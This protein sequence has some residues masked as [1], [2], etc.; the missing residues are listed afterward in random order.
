MSLVHPH[1]FRLGG[2]LLLRIAVL[3]A[4]EE[5]V[6]RIERQLAFKIKPAGGNGP[7][8]PAL[9]EPEAG[10]THTRTRGHPGDD[11]FGIGHARHPFGMHE[12]GD[13]NIVDAGVGQ[14]IDQP[15]FVGCSDVALFDLE[16]FAGAF[17][18]DKDATWN[19]GH[20][21]FPD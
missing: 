8:Q 9:I 15:Y 5:R 14:G 2:S 10:I 12:R 16:A 4:L 7:L 13:L 11:G 3:V 20:R 1:Q 17:L 6:G 18:L 19:I 21:H